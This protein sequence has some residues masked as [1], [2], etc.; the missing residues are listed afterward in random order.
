MEILVVLRVIGD[1]MVVREPTIPALTA[2]LPEIAPID[3]H[4]QNAW[5]SPAFVE[6]VK[7]TGRQ[8]LV[9][10]GI[11]TAVCLAQV[12]GS[13]LGVCYVWMVIVYAE[14]AN[15]REKQCI[16]SLRSCQT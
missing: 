2:A 5:E 7:A 9:I 12:A 10:G 3:R 6:A 4:T 16:A 13:A 15:L 8:R 1:D 11:G 14:G